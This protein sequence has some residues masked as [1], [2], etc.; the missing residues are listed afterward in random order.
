VK[1]LRL[2]V[3]ARLSDA[4]LR[5]KLAPLLAL[6]ELQELSLVRR[7]PLAEPRVSNLCPPRA[8][9]ASP[10]A[11]A[12]RLAALA[13]RCLRR[14]RPDF[15]IAFYSMPHIAYVEL[16]RRAFGCPTIPVTISH[17]DVERA[18]R[19][20]F[21]ARALRAAHAVGARGAA[22]AARLA[23]GLGLPRERLF[24]P[25]NLFERGPFTPDPGVTKDL[26][27]VFLGGL[28]P[29]K[30]L[31]LL[32]E[33]AALL[34]RERPGFRLALVGDGPERGRLERRAAE[35][36]LTKSVAFAGGVSARDAAAWLRRARLLVLTSRYEGLP[37]A[38]AEAFCCAVPAVVPDV[39]DVTALARHGENALVLPEATPQ[40]VAEALLRLL[41]DEAQRA[42]LA[43]QA[44]RD[45]ERFAAESS[46]EHGVRAWR[47]AFGEAG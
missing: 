12:F 19:G 38:L 3:V 32:L 6:P 37:M 2:V 46:L 18:L 33:A 34:A 43:A 30:R 25:P 27:A 8:L 7:T 13:R 36:G 1:P 23:E 45:G 39:G 17:E 41:R 15:L 11:E 35:L 42:R 5:S 28:H 10:A 22:S 29:V 24:V 21:F 16:A 20:G 4:K 40:G 47:G 31:G 26:D 44:E 9:S 14:P